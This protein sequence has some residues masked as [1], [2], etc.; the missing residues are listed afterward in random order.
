[1]FWAEGKI[2]KKQAEKGVFW[3]FLEKFDQ[4]ISFFRRALPYQN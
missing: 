3:H 2:L 4:K 1:M